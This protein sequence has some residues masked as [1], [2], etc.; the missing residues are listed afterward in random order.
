MSPSFVQQQIKLLHDMAADHML[1]LLRE[2][3]RGEACLD[4]AGKS[5]LLYVEDLNRL[6]HLVSDPCYAE[7]F[8]SIRSLLDGALA[9][10]RGKAPAT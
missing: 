10:I 9:A 2:V 4:E 5:V 8:R 6:Q 3:E 7:S 1:Q